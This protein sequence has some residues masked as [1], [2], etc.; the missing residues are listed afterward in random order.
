MGLVEDLMVQVQ[1]RI[2]EAGVTVTVEAQVVQAN[3]VLLLSST[4]TNRRTIMAHYAK[5]D[6]NNLVVEVNVVDNTKETELGG[7]AGV[8]TWLKEGWGGVDWKKTSYNT[9]EGVHALGDSPFRKNYAGTGY[10]Y[11]PS[12]DAF[13]DIQAFPSWSLETTTCTWQPPVT[14]PTDG[15]SYYWDE[16]A[17]TAGN[18]PWIERP[19]PDGAPI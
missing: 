16:D 1:V 12:L 2:V 15:K 6:D 9:H 18:T 17:H 5:L 7:E 14:Y 13:Y 19:G 4:S 11:D 3:Q 10:S 8:V